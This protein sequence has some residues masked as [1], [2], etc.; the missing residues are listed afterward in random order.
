MADLIPARRR[1][2]PKS[3]NECILP[4]P[5]TVAKLKRDEVSALLTEGEL[6]PDQERVAREIHY[7]TMAL[8]RGAMPTSPFKFDTVERGRRSAESSVEKLKERDAYHLS[9]VFS[10]W[11]RDM[12]KEVVARRP[13]LNA[14]GLVERVV[15][16]NFS[17]KL[18]A[19]RHC[20]TQREV[21]DYL[22]FALD[23]YI[24]QKR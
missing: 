19:R 24:A 20:V 18:L 5:E 21:L 1:G 23:K 12:S 11:A 2:R 13:P 4:T 14:L 17:P 6:S 16:E 7:F 9:H 8:R 10:P 22:R 15:N 3:K